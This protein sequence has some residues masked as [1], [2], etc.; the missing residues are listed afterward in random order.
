MQLL[1]KYFVIAFSAFILIPNFGISEE[2]VR[3]SEI[4]HVVLIWLK[5]P[6]N[7]EHRS[8]V[9]EV[10]QSLRKISEIKELRVG[11]SV[12]SDRAIVDDSFDVGLYMVFD[13]KQDLQ[14]YLVHSIHKDAVDNVLSPLSEKILVYDFD[15]KSD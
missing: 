14:N 12:P 5:E 9:I 11:N 7:D 6:T 3:T 1:R 15:H 8:R 2:D 13:S 4:V 10:T